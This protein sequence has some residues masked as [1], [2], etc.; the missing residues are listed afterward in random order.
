VD[1]GACEGDEMTGQKMPMSARWKRRRAPKPLS[2]R[3]LRATPIPRVDEGLTP[4]ERTRIARWV[5]AQ[6]VNRPP[7]NCFHC[8]RPIVYGAKWIELV[9]DNTRARFHFDCAPV[10]RAQQES[11][12]RRA[13]G[14]K[15][16]SKC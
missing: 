14:M 5:A 15:E 16:T 7:D 1:R 2:A 10:W 12:A 9:N 8:C 4:A 11:S 13:M 6:I 3:E